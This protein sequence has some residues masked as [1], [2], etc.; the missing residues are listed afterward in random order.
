MKKKSKL[1]YLILLIST[2]TLFYSCKDHKKEAKKEPIKEVVI[3]DLNKIEDGIHV[4]TGLKDAEG[5]MTV[6]NNCTACHAADIIMA[7]RMNK[8]RWNTTIA[9]MQ[10]T[11]GLWDLGDN[12][13]IIVNYLTKNYPLPKASRRSNLKNID[14][15][16]LKQ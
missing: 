5:L 7:N 6:V 4:C 11:Q 1:I 9:W 13:K 8:D 2:T 14:W 12:Q 10:K 16:V 15:Y 3:G